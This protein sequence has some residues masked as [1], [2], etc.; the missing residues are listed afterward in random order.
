MYQ[1]WIYKIFS[2]GDDME[3]RIVMWVSMVDRHKIEM[4]IAFKFMGQVI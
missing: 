4:E 1:D 2:I 3:M